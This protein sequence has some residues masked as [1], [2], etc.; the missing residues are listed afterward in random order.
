VDRSAGAVSL[1]WYTASNVGF[2][3]P[4]GGSQPPW[5][6]PSGVPKAVVRCGSP[7]GAGSVLERVE[8]SGYWAFSA[9]DQTIVPDA[10]IG[11]V[12]YLMGEVGSSSSTPPDPTRTGSGDFAF[13]AE[14]QFT[15]ETHTF[16]DPANTYPLTARM[17]T[18]G[19]ITSRARRGPD[20]YG[21]GAP[22][23]NLGLVT[24][25]DNV[26]HEVYLHAQTYWSFYVRCLWR[27]P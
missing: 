25:D 27:S 10:N 18:G 4:T 20:S 1:D 7:H 5:Y 6:T 23:F 26:A 11:L 3:P 12:T 16:G 19:Y 22:S 13:T 8:V 14:M 21:S 17:T 2:Y 24:V 15:W 9:A